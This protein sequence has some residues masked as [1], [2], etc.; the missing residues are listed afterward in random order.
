M[1]DLCKIHRSWYWYL[2]DF[3]IVSGAKETPCTKQGESR[4]RKNEDTKKTKEKRQKS[5]KKQKKKSSTANEK[6]RAEKNS[7]LTKIKKKNSELISNILADADSNIHADADS[8]IHVDAGQQSSFIAIS[9][10]E[11]ADQAA[12]VI[13]CTSP[14]CEAKINQ[15]KERIMALEKQGKIY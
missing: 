9:D 11:E 13:K 7:E 10:T 5:E 14:E 2:F 4:K 12:D 3:Y 6:K 8:N 1:C 15:L